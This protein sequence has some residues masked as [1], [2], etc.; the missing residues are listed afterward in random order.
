MKNKKIPTYIILGLYLVTLI[1]NI[2]LITIYHN[3][4]NT[5]SFIN[6]IILILFSLFF[7]FHIINTKQERYLL[8]NVC[9]ICLTFYNILNLNTQLEKMTTTSKATL[10]APPINISYLK[11]MP[12]FTNESLTSAVKWAKTNNINI[13]QTYEY[14]DIIEEQNIIYQ[15]VKA[16]TTLSKIKDLTLVVSDGADPN[17]EIV[18][19]DMQGLTIDE[20]L[21]EIE[22]VYLNNVKIVYEDSEEKEDSLIKQSKI[23]TVARSDEI[24]FTFSRGTST[25]NEVKLP[26]F[27]NMTKLRATAYLEKYKINYE[28]N[29][30]YSTTVKKG[31]V[32][33]QSI[34]KNKVIKVD[35]DKLTLTISKGKK[36]IVPD[37]KNMS[38]EDIL[39]WVSKNK[40]KLE[41]EQSNDDT[42][43]KGKI[44]STS[45]N[46]SDVLEE[47][48]KIKVT[49]SKGSIKM[50]DFDNLDDFKKW[51]EKNKINYQIEYESNN[52]IENGKIIR[53]S[54]KNN[55]VIK[56]NDTITVTVSTGKETTIPNFVGLTK[57][58]IQ[59]KCNSL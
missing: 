26:D 36:I 5:A 31:N 25:K 49:I 56:N 6:Y 22:K 41:I 53:F 55:D 40:L 45:V 16:G 57:A 24:T 33:K 34:E 35:S 23:G 19:K 52:D 8:V 43:K 18:L 48:S 21:D 15:N 28:F 13:T 50:K 30:D 14:S 4:Y 9:L 17:K 51:A 42:I 2:I 39:N 38:L 47:R 29:D 59:K 27:V 7:T 11:S 1:T 3:N 44:I 37:L 20:V 12:D 32:I 58:N 46:K 10:S 54:H